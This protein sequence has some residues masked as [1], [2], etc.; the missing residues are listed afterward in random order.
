VTVDGHSTRHTEVRRS[1][2]HVRCVSHTICNFVTVPEEHSFLIALSEDSVALVHRLRT[3]NTWPPH[4][5][6]PMLPVLAAGCYL[7]SSSVKLLRATQVKFSLKK[8][9]HY[10]MFKCHHGTATAFLQ[11][12]QRRGISFHTIGNEFLIFQ[13][14]DHT[15]P[16]TRK[17]RRWL[18]AEHVSNVWKWH[19]NDNHKNT[20]WNL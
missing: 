2:E 1:N 5:A 14:F 15:T 13:Q 20:D 6:L 17:N 8:T 16:R 9:R 19:G 7:S 11:V 18:H 10:C 12:A 3:S 4:L